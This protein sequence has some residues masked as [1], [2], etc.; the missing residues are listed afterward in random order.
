MAATDITREHYQRPKVK[1]AI[2]RY[3]MD[4]AGSRALNAD[5][6]WYKGGIDPK[7]VMLRGPVDYDATIER[8]R[9]LYATLDIM[10][11][12]VFECS[13]SWNDTLHEPTNPIGDL[14]DCIAFSLST[15]IDG[16]GNIR[17]SPAVKEAVEAATQFHVDYL[18]ERGIE[19]SV[20]CLQSGGGAYVI[21]HHG[22][23]AVEVGN[24]ELTPDEI[25]RQ[26]QIITKA[27][28]SL[29]GTIS[30]EF[31]RKHPEH[32]GKVKFDQ[33]N[34][35][36]R[37]F[38]TIFSLHARHPFAVIPLDPKAIKID[39]KKASLPLS[40]EVL[41]E[42]ANWYQ[43]F[44]PSEKKAIVTL[45]KEK[46]EEVKQNIREHPTGN[47]ISRLPEPLDRADFAPCMKNIIEYAQALEGR[48]RALGILATYLFQVGWS[49]D[50]AFALWAEVADR[51]RVEPRIF[52][53]EFGRVSCPLCATMQKDTG[54]YPHLNLHN[55]EFC[56][57]EDGCKIWPGDYG[58]SEAGGEVLSDEI[59]EEESK[60]TDLD[61]ALGLVEDLPERV[62]T[63]PKA[64]ESPEILKALKCVY[65]KAPLT[66]DR[67]IGG[68]SGIKSRSLI[69][70]MNASEGEEQTASLAKINQRIPAWITQ[71]HFKTVTDTERL[72]HYAH[73]TY[74]EDGE[75]L[76]RELIESEFGSI[77]TDGLV[78]DV[79]GKVKRRTYTSRDQFNNRN[80]LNVRNGLLD[81]E[82][83]ELKPHTP[84]YLSTAQIDVP[85]NPKAK[86]PKISKFLDEVAQSKDIALI[87]EVIGWLLW[88]GY[89]VH[90]AVMLLGQGRNGKGTLLRLITALLGKAN[91][92]NVTLQDLV[93]DR[94]AKA[95]LYGKLANIG[96][97][98]PS[99]D[100]SDTAAFRNLTGGDDNRAQEK[101]RPAFS[102]RNKAKLIFSANVLPRSPDDTYAFYSRWILIEFLKVFDL[103][104]GTADPDLDAKLQTPEELSGLL[105]IALAGLKR[106]RSNGW[107][108]SYD[109]LV[110]DV[111]VMYKRNANP[112]YAFL[113]DECEP[114][115]ATDYVEK[116][117][118]YNQFKNYVEAHNLRPLSVTK[119]GELLKDQTEIPVTTF[120]PWIEHGDRPMCW[121]GVKFKTQPGESVKKS[122]VEIDSGES[123]STP[124]R[125]APTP[126]LGKKESLEKINE[127]DKVGLRRTLDGVDCLYTPHPTVGPHPRKGQPTP[128]D[129][130]RAEFKAGMAKRKCCLC[131]RTFPYDL[132]PYYAKGIRGY[133]CVSCH[134]D[135]KPP[136]PVSSEQQAVLDM[137][138]A[139][140]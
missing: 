5:E 127:I 22:L 61:K 66:F 11:Q 13:E 83:L 124:S 96:G 80:I 64:L 6:H 25:K 67:I 2:L 82:K 136:E 7:T 72:Y 73:G 75:T 39:F 20:Y 54:G 62:K 29:I 111:E 110:E 30:Q 128:P 87:E 4:V 81:L 14:S 19:K 1:A 47:N 120:R 99:K 68:L 119:F 113:L 78:R 91:V 59:S 49:E 23:F 40:D 137:E 44:D 139:E 89:N 77:T 26:Y 140:S 65:D 95:D 123:Q 122:E 109:K 52:E 51:C 58:R 107:R 15:D 42:G 17:Q 106:L 79:V 60:A 101:Y 9:T 10:E 102:F 63:T 46:M 69:K 135:G 18:R 24:T 50:A 94:F 117:L 92:S 104:K 84:E 16:I 70:A 132:T 37:T 33:L 88:P 93:I 35:Q 48:H 32:I 34:N 125:V 103:Q 126:S 116:T 57:P 118:F 43:S 90:K 131:G 45:L 27:Y 112:V 121:Q 71:H 86:A 8:G 56:A 130:G 133:I 36:K 129:P 53:T 138:E 74:L 105:N 21:L 3:C 115:D 12:S 134:M 100:L 55:L 85:Y 76:L 108:F 98:L 38:K 28:N 114:G 41:A 31:F 97:D